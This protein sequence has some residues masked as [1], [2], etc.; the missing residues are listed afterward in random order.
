MRKE[1]DM[2]GRIG[3]T[4]PS[5]NARSSE[6]A[7]PS[8]PPEQAEP[9]RKRAAPDDRLPS[10]DGA[11]RPAG[12]DESA[13]KRPR[14]GH[15][16]LV[17]TH[18]RFHEDGSASVN[19]NAVVAGPN[20]SS[21]GEPLGDA[22]TRALRGKEVAVG[23]NGDL[24]ASDAHMHPTQYQQTGRV[25]D[26]SFFQDMDTI[27]MKSSTLMS[28]PTTVISTKTDAQEHM[29]AAHHCGPAYYVPEKYAHLSFEGMDQDVMKLIVDKSG[30]ELYLDTGVDAAMASQLT[31]RLSELKQAERERLDPMITGLHL[32]DIKAGDQL[33]RKL[34]ENPG[35]FTGIGEVT[36]AKELVDQMFAGSSQA[37][38]KENIEAFKHLAE[39]AGVIGMPVVMHCDVDSLAHQLEHRSH[40][41]DH[42]APCTPANLAGVKALLGDPRLKDTT[43]V[44]AHAG[45][46]GR[47]VAESE[48]HTKE[49]Q[50]ILDDNKNLMVDISWS[51]V[52]TQ[53]TKNPAAMDRWENFLSK[54]HDRILFGSDTL[55]PTD[56]AKWNET[57]SLYTGLLD[58]LPLDKKADILN[59]NY[60][61]VFVASREKVRNFED[62]VLTPDF[63]NAELRATRPTVI[64][65][66]TLRD[67]ANA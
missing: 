18:T 33:L 37:N 26:R 56:A 58:R 65:P 6:G 31:G 10:R 7:G 41:H 50:K 48:N 21:N 47:F 27:N 23:A 22:M 60:E 15:E 49:L 34:A 39:V 29:Q 51:Q 13:N 17:Q 62:K 20:I 19:R 38:V 12:G 16:L 2:T 55:A 61:R 24:A 42:P 14:I 32:G 53:L 40:E 59:N 44:W 4:P 1:L 35:V 43:M 8:R 64:H 52:A 30:A 45:G 66:Q 9:S 46:L 25:Y 36:L 63:Y 54:N 67:L 57:R 3:A 5:T 28:I 11:A